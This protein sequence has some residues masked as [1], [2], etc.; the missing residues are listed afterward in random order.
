MWVDDRSLIELQQ[1]VLRVH[2]LEAEIRCHNVAAAQ[3]E[4]RGVA[5]GRVAGLGVTAVEV[6]AVCV[7]LPLD[8]A[9][10]LHRAAFEALLEAW[11]W[12]WVSDAGGVAVEREDA[13]DGVHGE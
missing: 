4:A 11:V 12:Q 3:A 1:R 7:D 6:E 5:A 10:R 13:R 9:G 2:E 8:E